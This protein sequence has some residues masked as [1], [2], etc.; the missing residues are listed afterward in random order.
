MSYRHWQSL[1]TNSGIVWCWLVVGNRLGSSK[2]TFS[3]EHVLPTLTV[4][5]DCVFCC[6]RASSNPSASL[7]VSGCMTGVSVTHVWREKEIDAIVCTVC[8]SHHNHFSVL[9]LCPFRK[10]PKL[11]YFVVVRVLFQ[12][13]NI[14]FISE[15][16]FLHDSDKYIFDVV[17]IECALIWPN[18]ISRLTEFCLLCVILWTF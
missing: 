11:R 1:L 13:K 14:A 8:K 12:W 10:T 4:I 2:R 3:G 7:W 17:L 18:L 6:H 5:A 9:L 16:C 15:F